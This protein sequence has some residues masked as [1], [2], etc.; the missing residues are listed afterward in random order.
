MS[1][2]NLLK[3][4]LYLNESD[5]SFHISRKE[6]PSEILRWADEILGK[7]ISSNISVI[8]S[9]EIEA[10]MPWHEADR[11]YYAMFKLMNGKAIKTEFEFTR[12]GMEGDGNIT[13]KEIKGTTKIPTGYIFAVAGIYPQRLKIYTS[14]DATKFLPDKTDNDITD[15]ELLTLYWARSLMSFARPRFKEYDNIVS[16]LVSKGFMKV[17]GS[18]TSNGKNALNTNIDKIRTIFKDKT[19]ADPKLYSKNYNDYMFSNYPI[20]Y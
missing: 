11:E 2:N 6:I 9:G 1:I 10:K 15:K 3:N 14:D 8:Q 7:K 16:S 13:G 19:Y 4:M 18:I 17:N 12:S 5:V 20:T